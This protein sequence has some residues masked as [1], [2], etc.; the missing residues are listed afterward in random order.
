MNRL[1]DTAPI[2]AETWLRILLVG[3]LAWVVVTVDKR[4]HRGHF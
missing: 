1:F 2:G 3:L 4:V